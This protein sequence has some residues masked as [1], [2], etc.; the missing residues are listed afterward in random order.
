MLRSRRALSA[1]FVAVVAPCACA[2]AGPQAAIAPAAAS[3]TA[4]APL[5][6]DA[7]APAAGP[8]PPLTPR[9]PVVDEYF[10]AK[11]TDDYRWLEDPADPAVKRWSEAQNAFARAHLDAI[12]Q[13][14]A[15]RERLR[16]LMADP[17][18]VY[19]DLTY[20][21]ATLFALK[22]APPKQQPM[23]VAMTA[24][25]DPTAERVVLDP[26]AVDASG[27][28]A[29]DFYVPSLDGKR[30]AVSLSRGGSEEGTVHVYDVASGREIGEPIPRVNGGTAGGS[31]AW[32]AAGSGFYY[33]R[34][35]HEGERPKEDLDFYQQV[36]FHELS[37]PAARDAY[38]I[39]KD[40]PRIAEVELRASDDGKYVLA[41]VAN[42]DGGEF[43][44]WAAPQQGKAQP[45]A[46][47]QSAAWT[48]IADFADEVIDA[49][50]GPG[51]ALYLLSRK[52]APRGRVLRVDPAHPASPPI[53]VVAASEAVVQQIV[54]A[55]TRLYVVDVVG[56]PSQVRVFGL[57]GKGGAAKLE[58]ALP[59]LPVSQVTQV[60]RLGGDEVVFENESFLSPPAWYR[61][62]PGKGVTPTA[63]RRTSKADFSDAEVVRDSCTSR[64][65]TTVPMT[66][67]RKKGTKLDGTSPALLTG[68]GGYGVSEQPFFRVQN[69][70]WLDYGGVY[71]L[72]N[73]RGGGEYGEDWHAAGKLTKKQNVFDDFAACASAL[74]ANGTTRPERL[75]IWGGSNGGLLMGAALTQHPEAFRAVI[76]FV[77]IYDMLRVEHDPNGA[78]NVTEFGTV[79]DPDQFRALHAYSPYERVAPGTKYPA[80]LMLTGANDPRVNPYHSRKMIARL[81]AATASGLPVLLRTS[82]NTGHGIGTPLDEKVEQMADVH[83]FLVEQLGMHAP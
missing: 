50:F 45:G 76:S 32:N 30:V 34:Y 61:Y 6:A 28:A 68:Y 48:K 55:K 13:R 64:D 14:A 70:V 60:A 44:F 78:F 37:A 47:T 21:G 51:D 82:G 31:L 11:V 23:L 69:R 63:L 10:G 26:A 2:A 7:P 15:I 62:A 80:V 43:A 56:G 54:P 42:G 46:A 17:S 25:V 8:T 66:I 73:L 57:D 58:E 38:S 81:Q 19:A 67:V 16:E 77:G 65:G 72:A 9:A 4:S 41:R 71:A 83:A 33:T 59:V 49:R 18:P 75:A 1:I 40:F 74:V 20:R 39:G 22:L 24:A 36:Y 12:P 79:K 52:G 29:I 27:G 35:P 3:A 53:E 5:P